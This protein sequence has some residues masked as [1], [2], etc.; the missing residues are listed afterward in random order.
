MLAGYRPIWALGSAGAI[1]AFPVAS[2]IEVLTVL[3]ESNDGGA[4]EGAVEKLAATWCCDDPRRE[5]I[6]IDMLVGDDFNDVWQEARH[7]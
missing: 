5:L 6:V 3:G 2:G 4:N 7:A 1:A